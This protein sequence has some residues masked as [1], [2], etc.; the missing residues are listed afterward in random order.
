MILRTSAPILKQA[1]NVIDGL[2][3]LASLNDHNDSAYLILNR[4]FPS[5]SELMA[6][7]TNM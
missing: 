5:I 4:R 1:G 6:I 2:F 3:K 7:F